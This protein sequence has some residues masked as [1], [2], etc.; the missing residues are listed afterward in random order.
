MAVLPVGCEARIGV[1]RW[2]A[3]C[4]I[5]SEAMNLISSG[6]IAISLFILPGSVYPTPCGIFQ[7]DI[8]RLRSVDPKA[9]CP[10]YAASAG[11]EVFDH[12]VIPLDSYR[13]QGDPL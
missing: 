12:C 8:E 4:T 11:K 5:Q 1:A 7:G 3:S 6:Y 2:T 9:T 10:L 13:H